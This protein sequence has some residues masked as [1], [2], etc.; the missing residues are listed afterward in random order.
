MIETISTEGIAVQMIKIHNMGTWVALREDSSQVA[1]GNHLHI[2]TEG[3]AVQDILCYE[4]K[5]SLSLLIY[6]ATYYLQVPLVLYNNRML[7]KWLNRN[8]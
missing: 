5:I 2:I 8:I 7:I 4:V 3:I 1:E 6:I